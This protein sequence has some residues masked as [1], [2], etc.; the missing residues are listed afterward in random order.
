MSQL[1]KKH[2]KA[3]FERVFTDEINQKDVVYKGISFW[4]DVRLRFKQN[5]GA[6]VGIFLIM[7]IALFAFIAPLLSSHTYRSIETKHVNLPPRIQLIEKLGIFDGELEGVNVYNKKGF[8]NVYYWFGTDNL[9]RDIWTRVW[10]GT[11]V[12]IYIAFLAVAIDMVL[13][14]GYGLIS[15]Y[16]GGKVDIVMQRVIEVLSGIPNLVIVTLFVMI[17][18]PGIVSISLAL[19]ITGWIGMSRVVRSQV[20]KLGYV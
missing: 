7:I 11:R 13:G 9:G 1:S 4:K 6:L 19:V 14:I 3:S 17:L 15:G 12:S 16:I 10:V 8:E 2:D 5:K 18:K 20:L